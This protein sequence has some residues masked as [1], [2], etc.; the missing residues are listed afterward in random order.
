MEVKIL[1]LSSKFELMPDSLEVLAP[2]TVP[3]GFSY[4][5]KRPILMCGSWTPHHAGSDIMSVVL[6]IL[7]LE[8]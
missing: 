5:R 6:E 3:M 2:T 8:I 7:E 4:L 1:S